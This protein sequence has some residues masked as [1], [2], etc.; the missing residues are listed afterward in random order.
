MVALKS[1]RSVGHVVPVTRVFG[2]TTFGLWENRAALLTEQVFEGGAEAG[3]IVAIFYD[4]G[5]VQ[6]EFP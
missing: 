3:L 2:S 6:T 1:L 4:D 5:R